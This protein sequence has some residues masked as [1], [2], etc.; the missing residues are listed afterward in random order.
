MR[1]TRPAVYSSSTYL[2][3]RHLSKLASWILQKAFSS[4]SNRS[5]HKPNI[6]WKSTQPPKPNHSN[7]PRQ[8]MPPRANPTPRRPD[9]QPAWFTTQH[10]AY[11]ER[12]LHFPPGA[13]LDLY[14]THLVLAAQRVLG[15]NGDVQPPAYEQI[16]RAGRSPSS[17]ETPPPRAIHARPGHGRGN[18]EGLTRRGAVRIPERR[19]VRQRSEGHDEDAAAAV[20]ERRRGSR[21]GAGAGPRAGVPARKPVPVPAA[22]ERV[23]RGRVGEA[24][25]NSGSVSSRTRSRSVRRA[26]GGR[27]GSLEEFAYVRGML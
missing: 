4:P 13:V 3:T 5:H 22:G 8:N 10:N 23:Q 11:L 16:A 2:L 26:I 25:R 6:H 27:R 24:R 12:L 21:A 1:P 9:G 18:L 15:E 17:S 7:Q 20:P 14:Q 19:K